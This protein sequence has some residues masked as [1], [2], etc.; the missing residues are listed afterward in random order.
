MIPLAC[1]LMLSVW[2]GVQPSPASNFHNGAFK[3][4]L[5][6]GPGLC[7]GLLSKAPLQ[8]KA[9]CINKGCGKRDRRRFYFI[10]VCFCS[11][12]RMPGFPYLSTLHVQLSSPNARLA[13][14]LQLQ[15]QDQ[16]QSQQPCVDLPII[17]LSH[18]CVKSNLHN[19]FLP[20]CNS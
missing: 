17:D 13:G 14:L 20:L 7:A 5:S 15:I 1:E 12:T 11:S 16:M 10:L 18:D 9:T 4:S 8:W 3:V 6:L 19:K 2:G